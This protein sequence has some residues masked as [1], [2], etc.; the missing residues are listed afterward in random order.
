MLDLEELSAINFSNTMMMSR[1]VLASAHLMIFLRQHLLAF[2]KVLLSSQLVTFYWG[3][4]ML[5]KA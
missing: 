1:S 3:P 2:T 5:S 4:T